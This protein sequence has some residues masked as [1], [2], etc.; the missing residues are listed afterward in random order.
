MTDLASVITQAAS[1]LGEHAAA[2]SRVLTSPT[3]MSSAGYPYLANEAFAA[4]RDQIPH[5]L[6]DGARLLSTLDR[7]DDAVRQAQV[8]TESF[9][10]AVAV[11][12]TVVNT[13]AIT[14]PSD[15]WLL[16]HVL[17]ALTRVGLMQRLTAGE[18]I[19]PNQCRIQQQGDT[20]PALAVELAM[21]LRFLESRG[22]VHSAS[23]RFTLDPAWRCLAELPPLPA[24]LPSALAQV[25]AAVFSNAQP[26]ASTEAL[27]CMS[28]FYSELPRPSATPPSWS[29]APHSIA[30]GFLLLPVVLGL[31]ACNQ[32]Q[33]LAHGEPTL[34][35]RPLELLGM[36]V[37]VAA[38]WM[39]QEQDAVYRATSL[40]QRAMGRAPGPFGIIEAYHPY[41]QHLSQIWTQGRGAA[42]VSRGANVAASQD[43]NR[44]TFEKANDALDA[45]CAAQQF[46]LTVFIE[47]AVGCG[48]ATRQRFERNG[49]QLTY[50]GADL[51]D[52]AIDA[53]MAEQ[54]AGHLP[55]GMLFVR[56]ADIGQPA[57]LLDALRT[58][59]IPSRDAVMMVGN[60]FHEVRNQ[61]DASM[62]AVFAAYEAAGLIIMFTEES[63]LSVEDLLATGWNTYHAGFKYVHER[64]GQGLRPAYPVPAPRLGPPLPASWTECAASAGYVRLEDYCSRSRTIFPTLPAGG[65]NPSI[66]VNHMFI[67][68]DLARR[69]KLLK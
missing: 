29:A 39:A 47:H 45:F 7:V 24:A 60:G 34:R 62:G 18:S 22:Y 1:P 57:S 2:L 38:G 51:E 20:R 58:H 42:R 32:L 19:D 41:M 52:D 13:A 12:R 59:N 28:Q 48:E 36:R 11:V 65:H 68:G 31:R 35:Q 23:G 55:A 54:A 27:D 67:P 14:A 66:S 43:A 50:V 56:N 46:K 63:A 9:R 6:G 33:A 53:A 17:S 30:M 25:W 61:T 10:R 15:L 44:A 64:S 3:G 49:T 40:G 21:D 5:L 8:Q 26:P 16:R 37:L 69:L 4:L